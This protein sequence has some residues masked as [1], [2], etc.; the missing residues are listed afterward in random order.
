[1]DDCIQQMM[2]ESEKKVLEEN[3]EGSFL[4]LFWQ[5]QKEA[6]SRPG[7]GRRWHPMMVK[8]CI[9][10]RHLSSKAYETIRESG[11]IQLPS[12]RT[13]RDYTNCVKAAAG[14]SAEVDMLLMTAAKLST[15][16]EWQKLVILLLDEMH[17]KEDLV[18]NKHT[19][20]MIGFIN[21]GEINNHLLAFERTV[22]NGESED[23][24]LANSMMVFM[25]RGIFTQLRF[26]YVQFPC[27]KITGAL[28][29]GPFWQTVYRL[30]RMGLKV[31]IW[32]K[33][34]SEFN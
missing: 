24:I 34:L 8:W 25:V 18:Y 9:Y 16:H 5:Q 21:L 17:V 7:R 28:L 23:D 6:A 33:L 15:C 30:E 22:T 32:T 1:M 13:L 20:Q 19:G 31:R 10:L 11:C 29:F 4:R 12:Q 26:P 2:A 14:F 3:S 27:N